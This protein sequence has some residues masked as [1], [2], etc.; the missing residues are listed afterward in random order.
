[1]P[2][3]AK[4]TDKRYTLADLHAWMEEGRCELIDGFPYMLA[5]PSHV[6]QLISADILSQLREFVRG[7]SCKVMASPVDVHLFAE[8]G[9]APEDVDTV[10]QPDLIV[11][12]D[13]SKKIP[14]GCRGAPDLVMEI[15]SPST[16]R[17]DQT[18]KLSLYEEAGVREYWLIDP[19][20]RFVTV[21]KLENGRFGK[22]EAYA[23]SV[24]VPVGIFNGCA[25]DMESAYDYA[26][27]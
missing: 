10:V 19:E 5:A 3:P 21:Y 7:G 6:H 11:V 4:L 18:M 16:K 15:L 14:G 27:W 20:T 13:R 9:D 8:D 12:C 23:G 24:R 26:E 22:P 17:W 25:V 1:M 2:I